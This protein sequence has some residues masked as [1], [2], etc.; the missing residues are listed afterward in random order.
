LSAANGWRHVTFTV[1][2][3]PQPQ[4]SKTVARA[5]GGRSFVREDNPATAPWRHAVTAAAQQAMGDRPLLTGSLLLDV[6][7]RFARPK[8]HYRTGRHADELRADAPRFHDKRPDL[9][10]LL[11]ALGD[12]LAGSVFHDDARVAEVCA[13]KVY[14]QPGATVVVSQVT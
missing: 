2:G 5:V 4:G 6:T 11:R 1:A 3:T 10:K 12:A 13:V 14:G 8:S 7:F 9:D